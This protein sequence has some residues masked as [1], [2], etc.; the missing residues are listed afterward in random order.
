MRYG[1][2]TVGKNTRREVPRHHREYKEGRGEKRR[3]ERGR[4]GEKNV[5]E[6]GERSREMGKKKGG[7][8]PTRTQREN[9]LCIKLTWVD[10]YLTC[11]LTTKANQRSNNGGRKDRKEKKGNPRQRGTPPDTPGSTKRMRQKTAQG[12]RGKKKGRKK[13]KRYKKGKKR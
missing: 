1:K 11:L 9:I 5:P 13:K 12:K 3:T 8:V 6:G 10:V 2:G 4:K 7:E